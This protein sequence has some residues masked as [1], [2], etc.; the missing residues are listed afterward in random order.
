MT[1]RKQD[2]LC[3]LDA[4]ALLKADHLAVKRLFADFNAA[5]DQAR[6]EIAS[7]ICTA[8]SIHA[9]IEEEIL[10]PA[11]RASLGADGDALLDEALVE[12][13]T[14]KDLIAKIELSGSMHPLFAAWVMVLSEYIKHHV[15]EEEG[16]L[17]PKLRASDMDLASVGARLAR[18]KA[19]LTK[20]SE[21][22]AKGSAAHVPSFAPAV[23]SSTMPHKSDGA[24]SHAST[25][26]RTSR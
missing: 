17:F 22:R 25:W 14:A 9:Q 21:K 13:G 18:R 15:M 6:N 26:A 24:K 7:D 3:I 23:A 4:I 19:E 2:I 1:T 11:A 16:E 10:Y 20:A 8:L 5:S 12:H